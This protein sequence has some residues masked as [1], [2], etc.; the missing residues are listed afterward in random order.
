MQSFKLGN[1]LKFVCFDCGRFNG[2]F[3]TSKKL[4][5]EFKESEIKEGNCKSC[6]SEKWYCKD[7]FGVT[8]DMKD[9]KK[10]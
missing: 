5:K 4:F 3:I 9:E 10:T 8:I 6:G 1:F 2:K 7:Q